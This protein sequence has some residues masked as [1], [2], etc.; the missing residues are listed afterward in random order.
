VSVVCAIPGCTVQVDS[1]GDTCPEC[2]A[3]FGNMLRP[4]EARLS[5]D[6]IYDRDAYVARAYYAQR[7]LR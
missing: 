4:S 3:V 7:G 2:V 5:Q 6:E 1:W